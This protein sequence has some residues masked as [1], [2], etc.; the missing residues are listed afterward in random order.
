M[1]VNKG[2]GVVEEAEEREKRGEFVGREGKLSEGEGLE[3]EV[4]RETVLR[5]A[6]KAIQV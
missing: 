1:W 5:V 2:K 4:E 3:K 6:S